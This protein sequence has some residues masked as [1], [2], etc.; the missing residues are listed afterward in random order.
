MAWLAVDKKGNE[1]IFRNKPKYDWCE[2][3]DE[4]E[5]YAECQCFDISTEIELPKGTIKKITGRDLTFEDSP[6]EIK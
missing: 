5:F 4:E 2:W 3:L 6:F 1:R